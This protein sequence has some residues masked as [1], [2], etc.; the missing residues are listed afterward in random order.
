[1]TDLIIAAFLALL[2]ALIIVVS[3]LIQLQTTLSGITEAHNA[4][5]EDLT[6]VESALFGHGSHN[7]EHATQTGDD[8]A[9]A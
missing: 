8:H 7:E 1:M 5:E 6:D 2:V 4:M 9:A 3:W